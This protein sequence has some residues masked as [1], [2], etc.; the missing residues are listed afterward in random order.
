MHRSNRQ[1]LTGII[2]NDKPNIDRRE[3]DRLKA[4]L[5][6]CERHGPADQNRGSVVDFRAHLAG[7]VAYVKSLNA[8]RGENL[9]GILRRIEWQAPFS[10]SRG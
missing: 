6:N 9:E 8:T 7:R 5:T 3:Y 10:R 4:I 2:V 1:V